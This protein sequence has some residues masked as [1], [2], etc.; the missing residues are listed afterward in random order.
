MDSDGLRHVLMDSDGLRQVLTYSDWF[1]LLLRLLSELLCAS[2]YIFAYMTMIRMTG[3]RNL[4]I[5]IP[6]E[7][8]T[9][10]S[11]NSQI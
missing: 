2:K 3:A 7:R 11:L 9:S 5:V 8:R 4:M 1:M 6:H 10:G